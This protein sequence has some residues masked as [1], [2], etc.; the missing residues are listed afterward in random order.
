MALDDSHLI[1]LELER[2]RLHALHT[3]YLKYLAT[4]KQRMDAK[5]PTIEI[6]L[7]AVVATQRYI[8]AHE[9]ARIDGLSKPLCILALALRDVQLGGC[10]EL[11][12][13]DDRVSGIPEGLSHT[14]LSAAAAVALEL[15]RKNKVTLEDGAVFIKSELKANNIEEYAPQ[16]PIKTSTIINWRKQMTRK[17]RSEAAKAFDDLIDATFPNLPAGIK[18]PELKAEIKKLI[19]VIADT[20]LG[21]T[22][23]K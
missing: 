15:L 1:P 4:L 2:Q 13:I 8:D 18:V 16:K 14:R 17:D 9:I 11:F 10:P 7:D 3:E 22:I 20:G 21:A 19:R 23:I 6:C 5:Q 12:K